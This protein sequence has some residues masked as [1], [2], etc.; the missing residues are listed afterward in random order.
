M[1]VFDG[2]QDALIVWLTQNKLPLLNKVPSFSLNKKQAKI[3]QTFL[4]T[5]YGLKIFKKKEQLK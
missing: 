4:E 1:L 3:M 5:P 2:G